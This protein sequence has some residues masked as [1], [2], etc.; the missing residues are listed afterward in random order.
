MWTPIDTQF[1]GPKTPVGIVC[2]HDPANARLIRVLV[3]GLWAV[4]HYYDIGC[5]GDFLSVIAQE[6]TA[7][8]YLVIAG[9]G[10]DRGIRFGDYDES[11]ET[12]RLVDGDMPAD[13]IA[14]DVKLSGA[15]IV[16]LTCDGGSMDMARAFLA[17]GAKSYIGTDPNPLAIEHPLFIAHFFHSII[18]KKMTPFDAWQGAAAYDDQS[19]RYLYFDRDGRKRLE[20][21]FRLIEEEI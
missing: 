14:E 9:H 10:G 3:E 4:T 17:G 5:P 7:P 12:S 1:H 21:D 2:V 15:V 8:P 13:C 6:E 18:R 11:I 20:E 19:R 16:N